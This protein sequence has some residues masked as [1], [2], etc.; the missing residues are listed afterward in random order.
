MVVVPLAFSVGMVNIQAEA[1]RRARASPLQHLQVAVRSA[2]GRRADELVN[3]HR[4]ARFVV[5]ELNVR[6]FH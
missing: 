4:F 2:M 1:R 6:Q 5:H 3:A